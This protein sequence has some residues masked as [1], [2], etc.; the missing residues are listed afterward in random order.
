MAQNKDTDKK[1]QPRSVFVPSQGHN[2]NVLQYYKDISCLILG[3]VC[4][5][6]QLQAMQGLLFFVITSFISS[7]TYHYTM[8]SFRTEGSGKYAIGDFY[9]NPFK[10]IYLGDMG[11][12][13]ATFTMMWCLLGALVSY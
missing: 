12:Q 2:N 7:V 9:A 4:G 6:L 13:V 11:R 8:I 10:D 3:T 5:I 1:Q